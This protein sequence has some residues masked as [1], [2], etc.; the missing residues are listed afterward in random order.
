MSSIWSESLFQKSFPT[1][2]EDI[3]TDVLI[4]GGG[5]AG[6]LCAHF[7][8]ERGVD[9]VLVEADR[10]G[11]GITKNTTAKIT[12]QHGL[13]Y[14]QLLQNA[15]LEGAQQYLNANLRA[16]EKYRS[17]CRSMDCDFEEKPAFVYSLDNRYKLED[18]VCALEKLKYNAVIKDSVPLPLKTVGAVRFEGQAQFNPIKFLAELYKQ[19][20][21]I[22]ENTFVVNIVEN[23]AYTRHG[24]IT[25]KYIVVATHFPFIN[26]SGMYFM[27]MYQHRSYVIALNNAP[28]VSG[29]YVDEAQCGM[30]FRNYKDF[31]L[32]GGG[33][34]KTGKQGGNYNELREFA[35]Q[36]YPE[37]VEE[38]HWATQDCMSLDGVPYIGRYS[39][40]KPHIFVATGFNK[41]GMTSS[42]VSAE[43]ICD[44]IL[45][46][47][48]EFA[49]VFS[50]RRSMFKK[51]LAVN[52]GETA[53]NF[54]SFK[55][56][57]CS[58]LGCALS[59]NELEK[60]WDCPCHGS[61]YTKDGQLIDNPAKKDLNG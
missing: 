12:A 36:H 23:T 6:I 28:D 5:M 15:G 44:K 25:A 43:I 20:L 53:K 22:Y 9:Y 60:T 48:N 24:N 41:W 61:R 27:K 55:T 2:K 49:E 17:L 42:M 30:S 50:P 13:I 32:L 16:I 47:D 1:L 51:Q 52:L 18:E 3:K 40:S 26:R 58:H 59:W 34:H 14:S 10:V 31:L 45:G 33:D 56:K 4:I 54:F 38:C 57:R 11:S 19:D 21:N 7:L 8:K 29:M 37:G 35:K 46:E 39:R